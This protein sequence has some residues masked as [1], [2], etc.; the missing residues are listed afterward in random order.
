VGTQRRQ[1][2]KANRQLKQQQEVKQNQRSRLVRRGALIGGLVVVFVLAVWLIGRS[3]GDDNNN[4]DTTT[5]V[6]VTS[7]EVGA[8]RPVSAAG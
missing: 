3:G 4:T 2:Q 1:R 5:T 8:T 7:A 6:A